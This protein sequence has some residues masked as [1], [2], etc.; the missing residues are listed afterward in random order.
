[1]LWTWCLWTD[2]RRRISV[3]KVPS[4]LFGTPICRCD[5]TK[6]EQSIASCETLSASRLPTFSFLSYWIWFFPALFPKWQREESL[7]AA[8]ITPAEDSFYLSLDSSAGPCAGLSWRWKV[9]KC[10]QDIWLSHLK[11]RV[12]GLFH[13]DQGFLGSSTFVSVTFMFLLL[14]CAILIQV[15]TLSLTK[16]LK[17]VIWCKIGLL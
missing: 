14:V 9:P 6:C 16:G 5:A 2:P 8:K 3:C 13:F 1:M 4:W 11:L 10:T 17:F 15:L 12:K 7:A